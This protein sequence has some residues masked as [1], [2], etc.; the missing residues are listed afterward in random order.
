MSLAAR[1]LALRAFDGFHQTRLMRGPEKG[2]KDRSSQAR[3]SY[4]LEDRHAHPR[5]AH[6]NPAS[7]GYYTHM[8]HEIGARNRPTSRSQ[9]RPRILLFPRLAEAAYRSHDDSLTLLER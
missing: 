5:P 7:G 8:F 6:L 2:S 1:L 9:R 4:Y 3:E